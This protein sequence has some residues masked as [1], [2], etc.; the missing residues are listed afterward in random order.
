MKYIHINS[1]IS[2][3]RAGSQ[4]VFILFVPIQ[5]VY[6]GGGEKKKRKER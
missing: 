6:V 3:M 5:A 1:S 4:S 2:I